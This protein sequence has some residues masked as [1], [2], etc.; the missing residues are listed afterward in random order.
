MSESLVFI[1]RSRAEWPPASAHAFCYPNPNPR[2][3]RAA[4]GMAG[5]AAA[6]RGDYG[7]AAFGVRDMCLQLTG[8]EGVHGAMSSDRDD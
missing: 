8:R 4:P 3:T 5:Q 6:T 7:D 1:I 2:C